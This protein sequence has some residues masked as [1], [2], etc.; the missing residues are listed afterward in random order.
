MKISHLIEELQNL[1]DKH[2]DLP[3][4]TLDSELILEEITEAVEIFE[5]D[6]VT[7]QEKKELPPWAIELKIN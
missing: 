6:Y 2:G 4:V 3:V 7:F 1:M 5:M